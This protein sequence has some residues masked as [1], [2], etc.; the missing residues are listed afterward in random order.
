RPSDL[1]SFLTAGQAKHAAIPIVPSVSEGR[2]NQCIAPHPPS[3]PGELQLHWQ[4]YREGHGPA[5]QVAIKWANDRYPRDQ[6]CL[7]PTR[8]STWGSAANT[9]FFELTN[10]VSGQAQPH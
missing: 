6:T 9:R 3:A 8:N 2:G 5:G 7:N 4:P 1:A 10:N